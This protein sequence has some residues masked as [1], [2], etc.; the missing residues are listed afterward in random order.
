MSRTRLSAQELDR[1]LVE[2]A[3]LGDL[4]EVLRR[5]PA[6]E[7]EMEPLLHAASRMQAHLA[8][9][10][11]P[12]RGLEDGRRRLL[13]EAAQM[14]A[15]RVRNRSLLET[16]RFWWSLPQRLPPALRVV[17]IVL[18]VLA[19]LSSLSG[20]VV[21]A[22][23]QSL[24]GDL[25][26]PVKEKV[27]DVRLSVT[28]DPASLTLF[29]TERRLHDIDVAVQRGRTIQ[30]PIVN[31]LE[32]QFTYLIRHARV[33][34]DGLGSTLDGS[35]VGQLHDQ[36]E[37]MDAIAAQMEGDAQQRL[38]ETKERVSRELD[39]SESAVQS[40]SPPVPSVGDGHGTPRVDEPSRIEEKPAARPDSTPT[41][42]KDQPQ[43]KDAKQGADQAQDAKPRDDSGGQS[44]L[45]VAIPSRASK[46]D[47]SEGSQGVDEAQSVTPEAETEEK[48]DLP[49]TLPNN[50]APKAEDSIVGPG[51]PPGL[52][53]ERLDMP[54]PEKPQVPASPPG[55][56]KSADNRERDKGTSAPVPLSS[57]EAPSDPIEAP[58]AENRASNPKPSPARNT[59]VGEDEK[60]DNPGAPPASPPKEVPPGSLRKSQPIEE[61]QLA[62]PPCPEEGPSECLER[63][64]GADDRR[65]DA[66]P[67][68]RPTHPSGK[69]QGRNR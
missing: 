46:A 65:P 58:Q 56:A 33:E 25:L 4:E 31:R 59:S 20:G 28:R 29:Y 9:V 10:P 36:M 24:P 8:K 60:G 23:E 53:P 69:G 38:V 39:R 2:L 49:V 26:Y 5:Y 47:K 48:K 40:E 42:R 50:A 16:L 22:A 30:E 52:S 57:K 63:N 64:A 67:A 6:Q 15:T 12:P 61:P 41:P 17:V 18:L 3:E 35:L 66:P 43:D 51:V 21:L 7:R 13:A 34:S 37:K 68:A 19:K 32:W 1:A 45:P 27:E 14:R 54:Q 11:P 62:E 44:I 55:R